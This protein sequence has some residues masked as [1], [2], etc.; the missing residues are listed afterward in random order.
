MMRLRWDGPAV[1]RAAVAAVAF[2][3]GG[4]LPALAEEGEAPPT[5][6]PGVTLVEV[7]RELQASAAQMLWTRLG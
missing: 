2:S 3:L 1:R 6:P 5:V 7:V 4:P